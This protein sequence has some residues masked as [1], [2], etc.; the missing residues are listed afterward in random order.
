MPYDELNTQAAAEARRAEQ[1]AQLNT[2][3]GALHAARLLGPSGPQGPPPS[4]RPRQGRRKA[5]G[6]T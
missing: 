3:P 4:V 1:L 5:A 6:R 2:L